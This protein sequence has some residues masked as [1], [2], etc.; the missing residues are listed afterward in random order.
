MLPEDIPLGTAVRLRSPV[1]GAEANEIGKLI[2]YVKR[3]P[4]RPSP[5][6]TFEVLVD[7]E[8]IIVAR[9]EIDVAEPR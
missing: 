1:D 9:A 2:R 5:D 8:L 7:D 4:G 6:D 3:T